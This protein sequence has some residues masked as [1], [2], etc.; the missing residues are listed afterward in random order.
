MKYEWISK[1]LEPYKTSGFLLE[2]DQFGLVGGSGGTH[3]ETHPYCN[4]NFSIFTAPS[5]SSG[6][7]RCCCWHSSPVPA[8]QLQVWGDFFNTLGPAPNHDMFH[9]LHSLILFLNASPVIHEKHPTKKKTTPEK[10]HGL[11]F[12]KKSR[13]ATLQFARYN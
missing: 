8:I 5:L 2:I 4:T 13:I 3:F 7:N 11:F 9:F 6:H 10:K 12:A 1:L